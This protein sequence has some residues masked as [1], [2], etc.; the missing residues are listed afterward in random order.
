MTT[1]TIN[2]IRRFKVCVAKHGTERGIGVEEHIDREVVYIASLYR[3]GL[4][5]KET[6]DLYVNHIR[7]LLKDG[8]QARV[9]V[10]DGLLKNK[11]YWLTTFS[12]V[13]VVPIRKGNGS[14]HT[15]K[16]LAVD[17]LNRKTKTDI[18]EWLDG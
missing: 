8:E 7:G 15:T 14:F 9:R 17:G 10:F 11:R 5:R 1:E 3:D 12:N 6:F 13:E 18:T 2:K 4:S 16:M